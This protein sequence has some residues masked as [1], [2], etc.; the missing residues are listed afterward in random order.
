[1]GKAVTFLLDTHTLLWWLFDDKRLS[2]VARSVIADPSHRILVSSASAWEIS[3][4]HR[5]GKLRGVDAL[6]RD[7]PTWVARA[8]FS[9]LTITIGHAQR[10][11]QWS[12]SHRD[13]FDRMLAAQSADAGVPLV[14]SDA[15][16]KLFGV[17]LVW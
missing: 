14:T 3:T 4:K 8:G 17:P 2:K 7:L 9:E 13:P 10:A 11:G 1:V 5:L 15:A 12:V 16:L 6:V